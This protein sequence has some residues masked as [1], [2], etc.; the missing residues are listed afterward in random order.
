M[1]IS[2]IQ[3][4]SSD[5]EVDF[6]GIS[7]PDLI[8]VFGEINLMSEFDFSTK[9]M[10]RYP[11]T[12]IIGCSTS[13]EITKKGV[14]DR[15]IVF[16]AIQ[17][18][19]TKA[20]VEEVPIHK[21]EESFSAGALLGQKLFSEDL[22]SVLIYSKGVDVNGSAILDGLRDSLGQ[23]ITITGGLA[24]DNGNFQ[25]TKVLSRNGL[26]SDAIC[27]VGLYGSGI[28]VDAGVYGGWSAF[29]PLRKVTRS[30]GNILYEL[31]GQPALDL[32]KTYLGEYSRDLPSSGLLFPFE[33]LSDEAQSIG[34]IRTILGIDP[35]KGS[36]ILA[37]NIEEKG[38]LR[39][40]HAST[41]HLIDGAEKAVIQIK[42]M[43]TEKNALAILVS[44]VGRKLVMGDQIDDEVLVVAEKLGKNCSI[45]GFYSYG[46]IAPLTNELNCKLHNQTM[47]ITRLYEV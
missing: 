8:L 41:D 4:F 6:Q 42:P 45:T 19:Q 10:K 14:S 37:G 13:G 29:G 1:N 39:L 3:I 34:L 31:D 5:E 43:D 24:G 17:F 22:S 44:C 32:Y 18:S 38:Y 35:E 33:M 25:D 15:T 16:T 7:N 46:E 21:M 40:M 30:A 28:K 9:V 2:Q 12:E 27:A 20:R 11:D 36:L 26:Q 47:T 23:G